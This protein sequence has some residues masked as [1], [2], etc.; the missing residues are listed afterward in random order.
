MRTT[1]DLPEDLHALARQLAHDT[2]R[3]MSEVIAALIRDGLAVESRSTTAS[4]RGFPVVT[5]GHPVTSQ[6]VRSLD[7]E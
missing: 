6:D 5:V 4:R 3:S 7:D 1:V 2:N